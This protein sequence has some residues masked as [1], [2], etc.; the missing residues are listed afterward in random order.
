MILWV[1]NS[2]IMLTFALYFTIIFS[3]ETGELVSIS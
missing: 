3:L 1:L 2:Q